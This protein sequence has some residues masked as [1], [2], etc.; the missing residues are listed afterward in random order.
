M[1][2]ND[3]G[4]EKNQLRDVHERCEQEDSPKEVAI[5]RMKT[6][7]MSQHRAKYVGSH[8]RKSKKQPMICQ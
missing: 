2:G 1:W 6:D 4:Y 7:H 5:S 8:P 3:Q